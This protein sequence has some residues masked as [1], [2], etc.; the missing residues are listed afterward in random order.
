[1]TPKF[2]NDFRIAINAV[3][4]I[5]SLIMIT[6]LILSVKYPETLLGA[7]PVCFS[8]TFYNTEC[9][10]CGMT[11]AFAEISKGNFSDALK[12]NYLS[13]IFYI[14]FALNIAAFIL[15]IFIKMKN[16]IFISKKHLTH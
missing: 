11:R 9:F 6:V 16:T 2:K 3:W 7:A 8:K 13:L 14:F 12:L 15:Y 1:M 10:M 4:I 5:V